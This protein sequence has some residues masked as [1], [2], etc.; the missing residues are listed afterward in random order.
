DVIY[1]YHHYRCCGRCWCASILD[2]YC[3]GITRRKTCR[4]CRYISVGVVDW[5]N[6]YVCA[7]RYFSTIGIARFENHVPTFINHCTG[8]LVYQTRITRIKNL[9]RRSS[10]AK[11]RKDKEIY[12][13]GTL[14]IKGKT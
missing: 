7:S 9:G 1:W 4:P 11:V 6:G 3:R 10:E 8:C 12:H 2:L 14:F 13:K 5:S